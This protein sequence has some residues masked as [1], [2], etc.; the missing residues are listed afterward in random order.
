[1]PLNIQAKP[2]YRDRYKGNSVIISEGNKQGSNFF[3]SNRQL[4]SGSQIINIK[5]QT[6]GAPLWSR[7]IS[8]LDESDNLQKGQNTHDNSMTS[9]S[10]FQDSRYQLNQTSSQ[11]SPRSSILTTRK[12]LPSFNFKDKQRMNNTCL[13]RQG[14]KFLMNP[15]QQVVSKLM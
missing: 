11:L 3:N 6:P 7:P 5:S 4:Y 1:M 2:S 14:D 10:K 12:E 8:V 15:Q 13:S 9:A